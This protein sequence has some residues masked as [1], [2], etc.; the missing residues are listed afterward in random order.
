VQRAGRI[1]RVRKG[2]NARACTD[3]SP[4][5]GRSVPILEFQSWLSSLFCVEFNVTNMLLYCFEYV[6]DMLLNTLS[7]TSV[8]VSR[9]LHPDYVSY[10][11]Y[12]ESKHVS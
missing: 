8:V 10:H 6:I 9:L 1:V 5:A 2:R 12:Y 3:T 4:R 7:Y 11:A